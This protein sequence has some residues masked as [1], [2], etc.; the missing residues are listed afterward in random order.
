[1]ST[2]VTTDA[3]DLLGAQVRLH[4]RRVDLVTIVNAM[5]DLAALDPRNCWVDREMIARLRT[6]LTETRQAR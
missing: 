3:A 2:V 5:E 1:M 4:C 6:H